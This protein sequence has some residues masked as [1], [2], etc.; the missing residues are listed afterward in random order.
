METLLDYEDDDIDK[1]VSRLAKP[2]GTIQPPAATAGVA[3]PACTLDP[4]V[5]ISGRA[6]ANLKIACN[7]A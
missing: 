7:M 2:G 5:F 1:L 3:P 4:G 6:S